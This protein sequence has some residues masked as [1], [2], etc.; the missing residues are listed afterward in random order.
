MRAERARPWRGVIEEYRSWLPV[1]STTPVVTL[2]EGGTPLVS[3][4]WLS[5]ATGCDVWLK[6]EGDNP[7][8]SF[9]DRGMTVA[10][11]RAAAA[12]VK[13]VVC[14]STGNT[15]ASA[16]AYAVRAG[17]IPGVLVPEGRIAQGKLAQAIVHGARLVQVQGN[18][19]D[20]LELAR[21]LCERYPVVLVNSANTDG[22]RLAGQK[23][24]AFEIV[25]VLGD[26]PDIHVLPV[27]NAGNITAYW[28]GYEEYAHAGLATRCP[29]MWGFQAEGAAPIVGGAP[30]PHPETVATAIRVGNPARWADAV[31]ARDASGGRIDAVPDKEI[32]AAQADLAARDGVFVEPASAV[33]AAGLLRVAASG[34]LDHGQTVTVTVT[35]HGLK[36]VA[37][38]LEAAGDL[39]KVV[40]PPDPDAAARALGLN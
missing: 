23:T 37:T 36:D 39:A 3:S 17:M 2:G 28:A 4:R 6:V 10:V 20:C 8:G 7:T 21:G 24:A 9:K 12:G 26:A 15:S 25:D 11:S 14:A 31:A 1:D 16:A 18:F 33:G 32:L 34:G 38:A 27:G 19:D 35:G 5:E 22:F 30:V 29:R 13:A 40:V